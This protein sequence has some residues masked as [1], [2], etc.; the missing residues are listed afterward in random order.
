MRILTWNCNRGPA[1]KKL[2]LI[3]PLNPTIS[4]LQECP[5]PKEEDRS[6]LWFGDDPHR[7]ITVTAT[8]GYSVSTIPVREVPRYTVPIQVTGPMSFLL[9]AVWAKTDLNFHYVKGIIRGV[10]CYADLIAAQPTV[11]AGDFNSNKIWDYKRPS[12]LNHSGLVRNLDALG[13][14]SAYHHFHGEEQ[15][16]ESSPTL[17]M[18]KDRGRPYHID[19]CFVPKSWTAHIRSVDIGTYEAWIK[20]SD[21]C[22]LVVDLALPA[23]VLKGGS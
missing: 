6:T 19:Y 13:L 10:E 12:H 3:G 17:H 22:P 4:I 5:R 8:S 7:G 14:V 18:L 1:A 23:A 11:I 21:H 15:G 9:L 2:P 20:Y 16:A